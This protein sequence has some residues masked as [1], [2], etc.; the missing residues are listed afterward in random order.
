MNRLLS[1]SVFI[2]HLG[3]FFPAASSSLPLGSE[4][5]LDYIFGCCMDGKVRQGGCFS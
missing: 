2:I 1:V 3:G 4:K 5:W